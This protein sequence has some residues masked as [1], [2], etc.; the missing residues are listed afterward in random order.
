MDYI[1][2]NLWERLPI[3]LRISIEKCEQDPIWHPEGNVYNHTKQVFNYS[4][5]FNDKDLLICAIFHDLA[6][7]ETQVITARDKSYIGNPLDLP[8]HEQKISNL[9]HE[10]KAKIYIEKYFH[11]YSDITTNKEKIL[12]I[13]DN[14]LKAHDYAYGKLK[15]E[16]KRKN[17]ESLK[18]FN[19]IMQFEECDS[20]R[21]Q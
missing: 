10:V 3:E 6:K 8:L 12:E 4:K 17:F 13:C 9:T 21:E 5:K 1:F 15:K 16:L 20:Y 19:E 18:Y 14:H 11:L 2:D 7:P